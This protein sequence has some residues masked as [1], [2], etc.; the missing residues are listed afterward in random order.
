[1]RN[2]FSGQ[3]L[4]LAP[5]PLLGE[6]EDAAGETAS[7]LSVVAKGDCVE[8]LTRMVEGEIIPR[9]L[10]AHQSEMAPPP[11]TRSA[12]APALGPETTDEFARMVLSNEADTLMIYVGS[13]LDSGVSIQAIYMDLLAPTA[14]RLGEYWDADYCSFA[15]VTIGLGRLQQILHELSRRSTRAHDQGRGRAAL[16]ATLPGE[17]HTFGLLVVE[18]F[19]RRAGWR[20]W[21]EPCAAGDDLAGMVSGQWF[22][23]FG[24]SVS[25]DSHLDEVAAIITS[26]RRASKNRTIRVMVGGRLFNEHPELAAEVGADI[27]ASTGEGA[28]TAAD[29]A[30]RQLEGR[31]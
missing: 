28:V 6:R 8:L 9:L 17:Q 30:V 26:V 7:S 20:T 24:L 18:E 4:G 13:L 1:M 2:E 31:C 27:T 12:P 19:F 25:C 16:L 11:T 21:S 23:V 5:R 3:R 14:R 10:L 22:D 15:D 29:G